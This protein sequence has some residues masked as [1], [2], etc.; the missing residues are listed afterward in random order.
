VAHDPRDG[1]EPARLDD[2]L[3]VL[4]AEA[5]GDEACERQ[6]VEPL[7]RSRTS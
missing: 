2:Q 3:L 6:L 4:G 5:L 7:A 1:I